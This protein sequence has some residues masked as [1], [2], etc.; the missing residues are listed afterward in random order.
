[1]S[2]T[3]LPSLRGDARTIAWW[4][5]LGLVVGGVVGGLVGGV[6]GRIV[7]LVLRLASDANGVVSDDGFTIGSITVFDSLQLYAGMAL[8]G[9]ING[10][11]YVQQLR[12]DGRSD[13]S[14]R[15]DR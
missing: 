10:L 12:A 9:A 7:M 6:G 14:G 1:M 2:Q 4:L 3:S 11:A 8:V 5:T 13:R 15:R